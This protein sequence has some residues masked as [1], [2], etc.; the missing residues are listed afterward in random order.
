[1]DTEKD[2]FYLD[3]EVIAPDEKVWDFHK[4]TDKTIRKMEIQK[5]IPITNLIRSNLSLIQLKIL[6]IYLARINSR[7]PQAR[8][9]CIS[10]H[11][12]ARILRTDHVD[13]KTMRALVEGEYDDK[14]RLIRQGL[15]GYPIHFDDPE[16]PHT[17]VLFSTARYRKDE[18]GVYSLT[19]GCSEEAKKYIFYEKGIHYIRTKIFFAMNLRSRYSY[20]LY[21]LILDKLFSRIPKT[22]EISI[23][24]LR[25]RLQALDATYVEF[26]RFNALVLKP[27]TKEVNEKTDVRFDYEVVKRGKKAVGIRFNVVSVLSWKRALD[28][29]ENGVPYSRGNA[30]FYSY[31]Q[32][33][34]DWEMKCLNGN[35]T[36]EEVMERHNIPQNASSVLLSDVDEYMEEIRK[37]NVLSYESK[38]IKKKAQ[39]Q[40]HAIKDEL[41]KREN[42]EKE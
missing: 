6:D 27:A 24:E 30:E 18:F 1:M 20:A 40:Y 39:R 42:N 8:F 34:Q 14:R 31:D 5:T 10:S 19:L 21:F 41:E 9:V 37:A 13:P 4:E 28:D 15:L 7:D 3:N 35:V 36:R 16:E 17:E 26:K 11:D 32:D 33:A 23:D 25:D 38:E 29:I 22:F 12:L 2:V